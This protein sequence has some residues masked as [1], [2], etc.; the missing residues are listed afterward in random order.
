MIR[1]ARSCGGSVECREGVC[2]Q[3]TGA[4][5]CPAI[6]EDGE[7]L[8][9]GGAHDLPHPGR[10]HRSSVRDAL[11]GGLP[12]GSGP[13]RE[14]GIRAPERGRLRSG[15]YASGTSAWNIG[16]PTA[17]PS[18]MMIVTWN[19]ESCATPRLP[20]NRSKGSV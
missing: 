17:E 18:P 10:L 3:G 5:T 20:S 7:G 19:S 14:L 13:E 16:S 15:A 12:V 8:P 9:R 11:D 2:G 1:A 4:P 6:V